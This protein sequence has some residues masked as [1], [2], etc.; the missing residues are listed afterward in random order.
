VVLKDNEE[1]RLW[2]KEKEQRRGHK[3]ASPMGSPAL[4]ILESF[5]ERMTNFNA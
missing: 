2:Q 1:M 3:M 4:K 5:A